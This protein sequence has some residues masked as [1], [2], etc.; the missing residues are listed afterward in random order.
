MDKTL[1]FQIRELAQ[2]LWES[3]ARP[4]GMALDFWL[5][6]EQM[7][8]EMMTA[9]ARL[10]ERAT[11]TDSLGQQWEV[12]EAAPVTRIRELAE[13]M[14]EAAGRQYGMAQDFWLAAERHI[15]AMMR[16]ATGTDEETR[17]Y[18]QELAS[19]PPGAYMDRIRSTAYYMWESAGRQYGQALDFWLVAEQQTLETLAGAAASAGYPGVQRTL[20]PAGE[21]AAVTAP[22][23]VPSPVTAAASATDPGATRKTSKE[24]PA[25]KVRGLRRKRAEATP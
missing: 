6:A 13:L 21:P 20:E 12:P 5:M 15:L 8:L 22:P 9:T 10:S 25:N 4:Y 11:A 7:V 2:P 23:P 16:A 1:E 18:Y 24:S 19:L 14:W 17:R 3:A